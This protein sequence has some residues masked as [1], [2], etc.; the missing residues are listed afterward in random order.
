MVDLRAKTKPGLVGHLSDIMHNS[1]L[2]RDYLAEVKQTTYDAILSKVGM[3]CF[4]ERATIWRGLRVDAA[5]RL[6]VELLQRPAELQRLFD[7]RAYG[8]TKR[9][10]S[11]ASGEY[12]QSAELISAKGG[13]HNP[14]WRKAPEA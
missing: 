8:H 13:I 2:E 6:L 12:F 4:A 1:Q 11:V 10:G 7:S 5:K 3:P 9:D 14:I